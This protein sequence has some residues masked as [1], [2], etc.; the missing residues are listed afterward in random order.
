MAAVS[1]LFT[2]RREYELYRAERLKAYDRKINPVSF[3]ATH[4]PA[5]MIYDKQ[6]DILESIRY[7]T[8][9][10]VTA[11]NMLG[12]DFISGY[13][14]LSFFLAP[15]MYF[16]ADYVASIERQRSPDNPHPHTVRILTTSV[17]EHH[18]KVLWGEIGRFSTTCKYDLIYNKWGNPTGPLVINYQEVRYARERNA[19]NPLNYL[20]G[21]VSDTGEGLAGHHAAYTLAILDEASGIPNLSYTQMGTWAKRI[22]AIG[23]PNPCNNF[24]KEGVKQGSILR[25][26]SYAASTR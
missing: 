2:N 11:G 18:L 21:R 4:W 20:Q 9:T 19:K 3:M 16:D 26:V 5:V 15:Q 14:A 7:S 10:L 8:E 1:S 24:F 13:I 25:G 6:F 12:K 17:A 22:L 23:N